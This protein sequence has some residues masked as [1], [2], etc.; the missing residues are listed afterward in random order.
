[1]Q[2]KK[3]PKDKPFEH[4]PRVEDLLARSG[5]PSVAKLR[6]RLRAV[7]CFKCPD[8]T[9][10]YDEAAAAEALD[11]EADPEED[12][13]TDDDDDTSTRK[14]DR[15]E[16]AF[17]EPLS[18]DPMQASLQVMN[19][20]LAMLTIAMRERGDIVKLCCDAI[21]TQNETIK[22]MGEPMRLGQELVRQGVD[23]YRGRLRRYDAMWDRMVLLVEDLQSNQATRDQK[24]LDGAQRI[25][26]RDESFNLAKQYIPSALEKFQ[27]SQEAR[28]AVNF[29][30]GLEPEYVEPF[31]EAGV[32][33][34]E[35]TVQ[36]RKLIDMMKQRRAAKAAA[37]AKRAATVTTEGTTVPENQ[38]PQQEGQ[39][40]GSQQPQATS[41]STAPA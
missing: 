34:P 28:L 22:A 2:P 14:P 5:I 15:V 18:S 20:S 3:W 12:E 31:L 38:P 27:L 35:L 29:L 6:V 17:S 26:M 40:N 41:E 25:K 33:S 36:A 32:L 19:R 4:L 13:I 30:R 24:K 10:R 37:E 1:M 21:K 7:P 23:V 9:V 16:A 39:P 8:N 11:G